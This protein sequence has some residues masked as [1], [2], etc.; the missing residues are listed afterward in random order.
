MPILTDVTSVQIKENVRKIF[1]KTLTEPRLMVS[2]GISSTYACDVD[3]SQYDPT[4]RIDQYYYDT[5]GLPHQKGFTI[6]DTLTIGTVLHNVSIAR[7]NAE[8]MYAAIGS[9]VEL[10]RTASGQWEITGFS[11]EQPGTY[12]L[13][14]VSLGDLTIGTVIN[15][16][17][18]GR[19]LTLG[20]LGTLQPFGNLPFGATGI[21][22]GGVLSKIV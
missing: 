17:V 14:P 2:D 9:P 22:V 5:R 1:G 12:T 20:E 15:L 6:D 21:F 7:G 11:V 4:N 8:L 3:I 10:N 18:D 16:S 13:T 19:I